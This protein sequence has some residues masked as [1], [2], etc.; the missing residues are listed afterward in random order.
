VAGLT[1]TLAA[2][3][4]FAAR[5]VQLMVANIRAYRR[6]LHTPRYRDLRSSNAEV[7]LLAVPLALAL[8]VNVA[9]VLGALGVPGLWNAVEYPFPVALLAMTVIGAYAL[10]VFG[11]YLGLV[12]SHRGFDIDDTNHFSQALPSFAFAMI[13]V[14]FSSSAA[15]STIR[16]TSVIGVFGTF[17][18]LTAALAWMAVKLPVSFSAMLR[19]GMAPKPARP[20]GSVSRSSH[21]SASPSCAWPPESPTT[22][23]AH[24]CPGSSRRRPEPFVR[25]TADHGTLQ[26]NDHA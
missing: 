20:C 13:A 10:A 15:M 2:V 5:H 14:G 17:L 4:L 12:L 23:W 16:I 19:H 6:F 1:L 8:S 18:F 11:R 25:N 7:T 24:C 3:T 21:C 9:F 22:S 26:A